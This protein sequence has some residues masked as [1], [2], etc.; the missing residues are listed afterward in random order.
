MAT[1]PLK[2]GA[3][4]DDLRGRSRP[5]SSPRCSTASSTRRRGPRCRMLAPPRCSAS[6]LGGPFDSAQRSGRVG[7]PR[8]AG[9]ALRQRRARARPRRLAPRASCPRCRR[10]RIMTLAPDWICEVLSPS[11]ETLDRGKKLRIYA[12][13]G[14]ASC[15]ARRSA[16]ANARS[17]GD[18]SREA[19]VSST[20]TRATRR[21]RARAVRR[22][23]ARA[24]A[25]SGS[26]SALIEYTTESRR[27]QS[28][29]PLDISAASP[30]HER[31]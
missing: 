25:R 24:A 19:G 7:D 3:T 23:R 28:I 15:L 2:T 18:S 29:S 5:L 20:R 8:R 14:V 30:R 1:K 31:T 17:A 16:A 21:V 4:Y 13:E 6:K 22:H 9:A 11:T 26:E 10:M 12:R 27:S